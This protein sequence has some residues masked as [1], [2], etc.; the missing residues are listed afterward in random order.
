[1]AKRKYRNR[2]GNI[3]QMNGIKMAINPSGKFKEACDAASIPPTRRQFSKWTRG[4]GLAYSMR[5][6]KNE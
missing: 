3:N 5:N 6:V 4:M 1:M 2:R